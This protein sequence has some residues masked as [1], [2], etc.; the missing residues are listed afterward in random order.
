MKNDELKIEKGIPIPFGS[1]RGNFST[2]HCDILRKLNVGDSVYFP[3]KYTNQLASKILGK[4]NYTTRKEKAG[5][6]I[7]RTK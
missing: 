4:G 7:W 1:G 3:G 5:Y 2:G 6:R